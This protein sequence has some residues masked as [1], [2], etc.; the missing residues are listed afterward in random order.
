MT[1]ALSR[2]CYVFLQSFVIPHS[3]RRSKMSGGSKTYSAED[4][5]SIPANG[6]KYEGDIP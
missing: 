1:G 4:W 5:I 3:R 6:Q 2:F